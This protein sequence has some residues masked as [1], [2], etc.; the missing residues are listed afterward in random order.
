MGLSDVRRSPAPAQNAGVG[1]GV[2]VVAWGGVMRSVVIFGAGGYA[3]YHGSV[4]RRP[5]ATR[6][7]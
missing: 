4:L 5:E 1:S 6:S 2:S 3:L 7:G